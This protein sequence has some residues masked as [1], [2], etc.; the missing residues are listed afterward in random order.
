MNYG[1][2]GHF[3]GGIFCCYMYKSMYYGNISCIKI[4]QITVNHVNF[5]PLVTVFNFCNLKRTTKTTISP[6]Y[7]QSYTPH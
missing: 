6:P 1:R 7:F 4:L 5:N 3:R 2:T